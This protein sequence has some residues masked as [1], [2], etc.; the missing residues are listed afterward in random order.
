ME[1]M[2]SRH[3]LLVS[4]LGLVAC[5]DAT[6]KQEEVAVRAAPVAPTTNPTT[7]IPAAGSA[8][9][10]AAGSGSAAKV[11]DPQKGDKIDNEWVP[12]EFKTGAARWKDTGVYLDG[13]PVAFLTWGE[14]PITLKPTW[15]KDKVSANKRPGSTDLGWRWGQQRFYRFTDYLKALGIDINKVKE[16]HVYGPRFSESVIASRADLQSPRANDFMFRFGGNVNG[17]AI[18]RVPQ[19]FGG[20]RPPDKISAVMI[21]MEKKPPTLDSEGF[22]LDGVPQEG[23]PYYGEPIRGGVRVYLD[24]RLAAIIKRQEL[25]PTAAKTAANGELEWSLGAFLAAQGVDTSKVVE[26][27]AIR[28]D[29]RADKFPASDISAM[30]FQA[31]SQAK[32]GVLLTDKLIRANA[33]ALHTRAL[34][35]ADMPITTADDD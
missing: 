19:G 9:T 25:D 10:P 5:R 6:G 22:M 35:P 2:T 29:K 24:N 34:E 11:K 21:Y 3:L 32:G 33:I 13:K 20:G 16:M 7:S 1:T 27:W 17:K 12:A 15:L 18:P 30:T 23:V 8:P 26:L 14:L 31:S 4:L 28:D